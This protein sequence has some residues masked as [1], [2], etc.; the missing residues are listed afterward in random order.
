M[1]F[2]ELEDSIRHLDDLSDKLNVLVADIN[3]QLKKLAPGVAAWHVWATSRNMSNS[4]GYS[5]V[6]RKWGLAIK[7]TEG[8]E[9]E[10]WAFNDAPRWMRIDACKFIPDV[11]DQISD[12][13]RDMAVKFNLAIHTTN[14]TLTSLKTRHHDQK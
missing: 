13:V 4:V 3:E 7:R 8:E 1:K 6:N 11:I 2:K 5:R 10:I 14:N 12:N 9:E